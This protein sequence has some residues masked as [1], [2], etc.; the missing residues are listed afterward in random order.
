MS[1]SR[2]K[3]R[4]KLNKQRNI[5]TNTNR[6]KYISERSKLLT[7]KTDNNCNILKY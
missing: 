3:E 2:H 4:Q 6:G 1:K 5:K 7:G